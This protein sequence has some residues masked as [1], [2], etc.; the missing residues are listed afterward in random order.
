MQSILD[1][2]TSTEYLYSDEV[3]EEPEED[4]EDEEEEE[5]EEEGEG[6]GEGEE[7]EEEEPG[8]S[9]AL[10]GSEGVSERGT[11]RVRPHPSSRDAV[12]GGRAREWLRQLQHGRS[13]DEAPSDDDD[14]D[15]DDEDGLTGQEPSPEMIE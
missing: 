15:D 13:H 11:R 9:S 8:G 5:E 2:S 1:S 14:E 4:E 10:E 12:A 6:E 7:G 3:P